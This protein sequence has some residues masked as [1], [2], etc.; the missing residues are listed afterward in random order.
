MPKLQIDP[1]ETTATA[2][3]TCFHCGDDC[4]DD[5]I[6]IGDKLFC[7]NGCKT[8]YEILNANELCEY[9]DL[10]ENPGLS[11]KDSL[12]ADRFAFLDDETVKERLI[13]FSDGERARI[14][15]HTPGMHCSSCIW[16][17]E[18]LPDLDDR[19]VRSSVN[20]PRK[21]ITLTFFQDRMRLSEIAALLASLG[22]EPLIN[23][24]SLDQPETT[25][26][27]RRLWLKIGLAGFAFGNVM[28]L[29]F[30]EYLSRSGE[31][32]PLF[33]QVFGYLN[34]LLSIPV[35][36][37]AS[38]DYF[39]SALAGLRQKV[40][41]IDVPISLGIA[42]L[43]LRS[44]YEVLSQTG[45]G[46]FDSF[47]GLVFFLLI[48]RIFQQKTYDALSFERDYKA[49]FPLSATQKVNQ[50]EVTTPVNKLK[51]GDRIVV[52]NQELIP[53][54]S[55]LLKSGALIDYS[56]VTGESN[57]VEKQHGDFIYAGGRQVGTT[58]ELEVIKE[59]SQSYLTSLWN[60]EVFNKPRFSWLSSTV[61][62]IS[63][64]FTFVV[65]AIALM[66]GG[67]WLTRDVSTAFKAFTAVLIVACPCALA[68]ASP[69][70]LGTAMRIFG[71]FGFYVKNTES[72]E[73]MTQVDA[74]VMDKTGTLTEQRKEQVLFQGGPLNDSEQAII[75][76]LVR[77]STH[78]LSQQIHQV[79]GKH[80]SET[81][82]DFEELTGR[83]L[84]GMV[85]GKRIRLGSA[86]W[87]DVPEIDKEREQLQTRVYLE[88]DGKLRG[89]F[90]FQSVYRQGL[91]ALLARLQQRFSLFLL[92]GDSER[93]KPTLVSLFGNEEHLA[94]RQAPEDKLAFVA[95]LQRKG[96]HVM[97]V[98]DG[99]N[100]AG[101]LRA[102]EVGV[103]ITEDVNA[104]SPASDAILTGRQLHRLGT[105]LTLARHTRGVIIAAFVISFLYNI[106]G[107]GFAVSGLLS[108]LVSAI[109]MPTSSVTVVAFST[110]M[111]GFM[112]RRLQLKVGD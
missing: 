108:P 55:V 23:L 52:R 105:F 50:V 86:T 26:E 10:D 18:K 95:D 99:L 15:L 75:A 47:T 53:A 88:I 97:M 80:S 100:D 36:L 87:L 7:C 54:D 83:G 96:H 17:L 43:F 42:V 46:Y 77:H 57:P 78:P 13:T 61:D 93:E 35:L 85:A 106:V 79:L 31:V 111:T 81:I 22:Y 5:S 25:Q 8:V 21:E 66:A 9:Y 59:P 29:S 12:V 30:P 58:I 28:L 49:Y 67:F 56:F 94:F 3:M 1:L 34:L 2:D 40:V 70:A 104:F 107:I 24:D 103:A 38:Q 39:R 112:A 62:R 65:L 91:K 84:V 19:V 98:G 6:R 73:A 11:P 16:L 27:Q 76:S 33:K 14:T 45:A 90:L 101:A 92:S 37:Y 109:L 82:D 63:K 20:F 44:S 71:R 60:N 74:I 48:G 110:L 69:F 89:H 68:L 32:D 4:P 41:N 51:P 64:Y 72:V 102:S